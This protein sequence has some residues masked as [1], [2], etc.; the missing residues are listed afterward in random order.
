MHCPKKHWN[1]KLQ[2]FFKQDQEKDQAKEEFIQW[3]NLQWNIEFKC[4]RQDVDIQGSPERTLS[5][6]VIED[7]GGTLFFLE[8]FSKNK[9][10]IR[11]NVAKAIEY[12]NTNGLKQALPYKKTNQNEFLPF[13]QGAC[14]QVSSF[15]DST[16]IKRPDYLLSAKTGESFALFLSHLSKA[17]GNIKSETLFQPFFIN[18]Y[19]YKLFN[20][21]ETH[22]PIVY[23]KYFPFLKFLE[24]NFMNLNE[25]LPL[26]FCHGD[27]HPLNVIWDDDQIKA[28][29]DWEFT[30]F[31]PD[32]YD[33]ANLVGCAG[34]ENPEG[35]SMPMVTTFIEV[36]KKEGNISKAGWD[37]F[38]EYIIA[39]RFAWVSEWLR[40]K[41]EEM[42]ELEACYLKILIK[43]L[44]TLRDI[45]K[46]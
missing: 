29:I 36:L 12:L 21:M 41:D 44:D 19:I 18:K 10:Q 9:F 17:S 40:K 27:L 39:Q 32:I 7:K 1:H 2:E 5:R 8:K 4:V 31:K 26:S 35:L 33:A 11:Q 23:K 43:N 42:L 45:W 6:I 20:Q 37:I 15:L 13:Y 3:L 24:K 25:E 46:I 34:I 30:G 38:P 22:D 16:G 14:F 28:V